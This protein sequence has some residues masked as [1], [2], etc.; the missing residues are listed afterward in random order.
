LEN[1]IISSWSCGS[2]DAITAHATSLACSR[3]AP[4]IE[5]LVSMSMMRSR[6]KVSPRCAGAGG[7][8]VSRPYAD[9]QIDRSAG[10]RATSIV[11]PAA[12]SATGQRIT[13]SR[14]SRAPP[15]SASVI[16]VRAPPFVTRRSCDGL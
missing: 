11:A 12:D 4:V 15:S 16:S 5:P 8:T 9:S 13:T 6:G 1:S 2:I 14:S 10:G 3:G 7:T